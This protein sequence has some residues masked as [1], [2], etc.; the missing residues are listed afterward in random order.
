[1]SPHARSTR[2][3]KNPH[4]PT[5]LTLNDLRVGRHII[6]VHARDGIQFEGIVKS[7]PYIVRQQYFENAPVSRELVIDVHAIRESEQ[8]SGPE[9]FICDLGIGQPSSSNGKPLWSDSVYTIDARER[10]LLLTS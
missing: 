9:L 6:V 7:S 4:H 10:S 2:S 8:L 3:G 1:M 5:V